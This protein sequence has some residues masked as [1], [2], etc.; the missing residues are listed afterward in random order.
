MT[1][2]RKHSHLVADNLLNRQFNPKR[3]NQI[4]AGN[5]TYLRTHLGW[6]YLAIVMDL[7]SRRI[8]GWA[9]NKRMTVDLTMRTFQMA[10]NLRQPKAGLMFHSDRG[11]QYTSKRYR[12]S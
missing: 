9:L 10:V 11:S 1:T 3:A 4:W 2:L 8:I 7:H 6:M 5:I 12:I